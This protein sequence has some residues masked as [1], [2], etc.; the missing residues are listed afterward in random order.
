MSQTNNVWSNNKFTTINNH[1]IR[2]TYKGNLSRTKIKEL[3]KEEE[4]KE[5]NSKEKESLTIR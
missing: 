1:L 3:I 5:E 4:E 2:W